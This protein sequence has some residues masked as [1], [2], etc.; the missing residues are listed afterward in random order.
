[1]EWVQL[2]KLN[3]VDV[4]LGSHCCHYNGEVVSAQQYKKMLMGF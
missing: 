3:S 4:Y 2:I 1:M